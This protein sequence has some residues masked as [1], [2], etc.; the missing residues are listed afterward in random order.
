MKNKRIKPN[1]SRLEPIP[2]KDQ[3]QLID[4]LSYKYVDDTGNERVQSIGE[5]EEENRPYFGVEFLR[6]K[7]EL[8]S[9][10]KL[11]NAKRAAFLFFQT[12][13][14]V[15]WDEFQTDIRNQSNRNTCS[16]FAMVAAIEARYMRD[17]GLNLNLSE[18]FFWH[19]YKSTGLSFPKKYKYENQSSYW[20]GGNSQG[21]RQSVNFAIPLEQDCPYLN[22]NGMQNIR[23]Q[24]PLAGQLVWNS[25]PTQN[26]V[27]QDEV[28]AFEYSP[29]YISDQARQNARYGVKSYILF[30]PS[31]IKNTAS[32][33][34][35]LAW[36]YE[37]IVDANLKW[38]TDPATGIREYNASSNGA[39]HSFLVVGYD[40]D[41]QVFYVK[42]SH[43]EAGLIRVSY[44]FAE[45]CFDH[46]SIV[47]AVTD[48]EQPTTKGRAIGIWQ[49]NHDGWKGELTIRRFTNENNDVTRLGHYRSSNGSIKAINGKYVHDGRGVYFSLTQGEDSDPKSQTGQ[50]FTM[51]VYSWDVKHAAGNTV[52]SNIPFGSYMSRDEFQ[53][54]YAKDFQPTKWK[55]TWLMNHDGWKGK[56][57]ISQVV[58]IP[59]I[60]WL[61]QGEYQPANGTPK[62]IVGLLDSQHSHILRFNI[63]FSDENNQPFVLHFHTWSSD[64]ASGYT[65]WNGKRFGAV[66]FKG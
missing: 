43:G 36:G 16:G 28:D 15:L 40:R 11:M 37:V 30:D 35:L 50:S 60:G 63:N 6:S 23:D 57:F 64:L 66:A 48:P 59:L 33:E 54:A 49:M 42:N 39:W 20:G 56:L 34:W 14:S 5:F 62:A 51:D 65:F 44:E 29:L 31:T 26:T 7:R 52:W 3:I 25:D 8:E 58:P 13:K 47:T 10:S 2:D 32:L 4:K 18:Q 1:L 55:G 38:K 22:R 9:A 27:T 45:N 24:I 12:P 41:D 17:Y 61:V 46:G 21:L 53:S 19:C